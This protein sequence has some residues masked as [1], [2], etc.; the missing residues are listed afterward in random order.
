MLLP[1]LALILAASPLT[2][3]DA[4]RL[5]SDAPAVAAA[6]GAVAERRRLG[7]SVSS[8]T[9]NPQ[10]GVQPGV[11]KHAAGVGPDI[12]LS[13]TQSLNLA[14][15]GGARKEA[16]ARELEHD[17]TQGTSLLHGLRLRAARAWLALWA[18]QTSWSEAKLELE[19]ATDWAKRVERAS[20]AG[21]LTKA[22]AAAARGWQAEAALAVLAAHGE[23]FSSGVML[24]GV[25]GVDTREPSLAAAALPELALPDAAVLEQSLA[26]ADR[27]PAV[28]LLANARD[29]EQAHLTEV[30]AANGTW[31]QVGVQAGREG[32]GDLVGV[33]VLQLTIPAFDR[34]ERDQARFRALAVR[35]EGDRLDALARARAE[36]VDVIHEVEH[37]REVLDLV[38]GALLPAAEDAARF[39]QK[40]MEGGEGTAFEWVMARRT[41]LMAKSR[42]VR[43]Q[44]DHTMS[45]FAAAELA[46]ATGESP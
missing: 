26:R 35:A 20:V 3:E 38:E 15:F 7:D 27:A 28:R 9:A 40:R 5:A 42:K 29:A 16:L 22:D 34:A 30:K 23:I 33:G 45:R 24:S 10:L 13:L 18:A 37:T 19:L 21:G 14:G 4:L 46:A 43:A 31:L 8:L 32:A 2:F 25:L 12:Y 39:A 44:A 36:R 41:V 1:P 17:E 11:R 6:R